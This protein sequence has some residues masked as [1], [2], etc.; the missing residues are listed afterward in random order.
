MKVYP[1]KTDE[2][3]GE[4]EAGRGAAAPSAE[5]S[6]QALGAIAHDLKNLLAAIRGFATVIAE[7]LP[8]DEMVRA[9][10]DQIV[11]AVDRGAVLAQRLV[12]L[13]GLWARPEA[14]GGGVPVPVPAQR[15]N[16]TLAARVRTETILI[17]EDDELVRLMAA[18]VL[19]RRGFAVLEAANAAEAEQRIATHQGQIDL[20]L[21]DI[22]L[23]EVSGPDLVQRLKLR[24]PGVRVLFMSGFGRATLAE[25]GISPGPGL[26]EKPFA[27]EV[28]VERIEATLAAP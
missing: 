17:T 20:L 24:L 2:A 22:G 14:G 4:G 15:S 3:D 27:P 10:L 26:L 8:D 16:R 12:A 6:E 19:Q 11:K 28:L 5:A 25:L 7:D 18:R 21:T 1:V 13:R 9:D 23:P